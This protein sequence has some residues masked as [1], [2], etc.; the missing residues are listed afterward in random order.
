[1]TQ[2]ER[3]ASTI[4]GRFVNDRIREEENNKRVFCNFIIKRDSELGETSLRA[5]SEIAS[6]EKKKKKKRKRKIDGKCIENIRCGASQCAS[7]LESRN[8]RRAM[9]IN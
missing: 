5:T 1:M 3:N 9:T 8:V 4:R 7:G 2:S 6:D